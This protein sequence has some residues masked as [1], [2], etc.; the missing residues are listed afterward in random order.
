MILE[1][2]IRSDTPLIVE[3]QDISLPV[4]D[5]FLGSFAGQR[6]SAW[7]VPGVGSRPGWAMPR[8]RR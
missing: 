2:A 4:G 6:G 3:Y 5:L 7:T 1:E 8:A